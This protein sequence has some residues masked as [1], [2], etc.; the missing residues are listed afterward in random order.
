MYDWAGATNEEAG[1]AGGDEEAFHLVTRAPRIV[2]PRDG[3]TLKETEMGKAVLL[4][5]EI[6]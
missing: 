6:T 5:W 1:G 4:F 3:T 2:L